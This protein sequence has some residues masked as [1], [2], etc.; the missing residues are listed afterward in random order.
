MIPRAAGR[1]SRQR[2]TRRHWPALDC[3]SSSRQGRRRSTSDSGSLIVAAPPARPAAW[4]K[5][6][7]CA[8]PRPGRA[9]QSSQH[10]LDF[11]DF[12]QL[13]VT[14]IIV[15]YNNKNYGFHILKR[16]NIHAFKFI[17]VERLPLKIVMNQC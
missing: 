17:P 15:Y 8:A 3:A 16:I 6:V 11:L 12:L 4:K 10:P 9:R 2:C 5:S 1:A 13:R 14:Q 7:P